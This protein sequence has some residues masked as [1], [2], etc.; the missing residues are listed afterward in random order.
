[1]EWRRGPHTLLGIPILQAGIFLGCR[2]CCVELISFA[3]GTMDEA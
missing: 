1:M 2:R 3:I